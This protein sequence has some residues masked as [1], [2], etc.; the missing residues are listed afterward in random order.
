MRYKMTKETFDAKISDIMDAI[1]DKEI[2][3]AHTLK[4]KLWIELESDK[5][6]YGQTKYEEGYNAGEEDEYYNNKPDRR[7]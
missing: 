3:K 4:A 2:T 7:Y 6:D 1:I 5:E